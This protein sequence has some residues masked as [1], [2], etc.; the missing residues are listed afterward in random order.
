MIEECSSRRACW[1]G[2]DIKVRH[3]HIR[4]FYGKRTGRYAG[5]ENAVRTGKSVIWEQGI[6]L[7]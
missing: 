5:T 3:G 1:N 2:R 7:G 6:P 4:S